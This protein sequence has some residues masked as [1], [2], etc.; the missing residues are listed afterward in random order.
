MA[1]E[2]F[3]DAHYESNGLDWANF[4]CFTL[5]K[6]AESDDCSRVQ[7]VLGEIADLPAGSKAAFQLLV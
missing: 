5:L 1:P 6:D 4:G 7:H 2:W 3:R